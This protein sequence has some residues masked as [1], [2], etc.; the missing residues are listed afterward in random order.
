MLFPCLLVNNQEMDKKLSSGISHHHDQDA[1]GAIPLL[2]H[3]C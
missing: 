1:A 3:A 2:F